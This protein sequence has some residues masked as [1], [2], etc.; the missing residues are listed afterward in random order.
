MNGHGAGRTTGPGRMGL[1]V[2]LVVAL[3]VV[4]LL[5]AGYLAERQRARRAQREADEAVARAVAAK[6]DAEKARADAVAARTELSAASQQAAL[7]FAAKAR[8][9]FQARRWDEAAEAAE[10]ALSLDPASGAA[11]FEEGRLEFRARNFDAARDTLAK[12]SELAETDTE[13]RIHATSLAVLAREYG[14]AQRAGAGGKL[15]NALVRRLS[16]ELRELDELVLAAEFAKGTAEGARQDRLKLEAGIK[17]LSES[18]PG[19]GKVHY[20][21]GAEGASMDAQ[22]NKRL[23]DLG[24]LAGVPF[25]RLNLALTG[26]EDLSPVKGMPLELLQVHKT[27]VSDL[28]PL[29]GMRLK[30][31]TLRETQVA[32]LSALRGM[33]LEQLSAG[34]TR[35]RDFSPLEGAPIKHLSLGRLGGQLT[36]LS[37]VKGMPLERLHIGDSKVAS[38]EPLRGLPLKVLEAASS[39]IR[40]LSPL[41]GMPLEKLDLTYCLAVA[42]LSPLEGMPLSYLSVRRCQVTDLSPLAGMPL[43]ELNIVTFREIEDYAV[44]RDL[45]LEKLHFGWAQNRYRALERVFPRN[46]EFLREKKTLVWING[47]AAEFWKLYDK[48]EKVYADLKAKNPDA[49][50][51]G[52][53]TH[54][55]GR[56]GLMFRADFDNAGLTDLRAF[57]GLKLEALTCNG[58]RIT[59]LSPLKGMGLQVL[60]VK[61]LERI[62]DYSVLADMPLKELELGYVA[63]PDKPGEVELPEGLEF[64][65]AMETLVGINGMEKAVFLEKYRARK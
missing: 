20:G 54:D 14:E 46:L 36:D 47:P 59:D 9:A 42:D 38:L 10:T 61:S 35:V 29:Q 65:D 63:D 40:D 27:A 15:P 5:G 23:A 2:G 26:V 24:P 39:P 62:A 51:E 25:W 1:I 32:D 18:N 64:L 37:F 52:R 3:V 56:G 41:K 6:A 31:L 11:M 57:G 19:L 49:N 4:A 45:P 7:E 13:R 34:Q 28:T 60:H 50:G 30:V 44:L 12:A 22:G 17:G 55:L 8:R 53:F 43:R 21:S 48:C 33:P 16:Q 58:N